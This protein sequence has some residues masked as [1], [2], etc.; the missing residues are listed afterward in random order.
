MFDKITKGFSEQAPAEYYEPQ[1][2]QE[3]AAQILTDVRVL[4]GNVVNLLTVVQPIGTI[5]TFKLDN[6]VSFSSQGYLYNAVLVNDGDANNTLSVA[7]GGVTYTV[8]LTA[9]LNQV[10]FPDGADITATKATTTVFLIRSNH[11]YKSA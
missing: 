6:K 2:S 3:T 8:T 11:E 7:I 5:E 9:G 10:N 1:P 4:L